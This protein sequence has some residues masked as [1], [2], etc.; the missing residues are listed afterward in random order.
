MNNFRPLFRLAVLSVTAVVAVVSAQTMPPRELTLVIGRGELVQ[1]SN[2]VKTVATSEPKIADVSVVSPR[3]VMIN[4]KGLGKSTVIIWE[5]GGTPSRYNINVQADSME[6]D[7]VKK[8]ITEAMN[9]GT[10]SVTGNLDTVVLSGKAQSVEASKKAEAI[11]STYG[12]KV[13]NLIQVPPPAEL[14]QVMLEVKFAAIDRIALQE[15]GFNFLSRNPTMLGALSTQQFSTPRFS[16]LQFQDQN[17]SNSTLNF[18][19]LLNMFVFRPDLNIGATIRALQSRNLLQMLAEPNLIALEGK[20]ASFLAGGEFPFP[21]LTATST[22]GATAPVVTVQFK[23]FGVQLDFKPEITTDNR[24]HLKLR[25]QVS[26]LDYANAVTLQGY[27]IPAVATRFAETEAI[28]NDGESFAVA[29]LIDNRVI[30][31]MNKIKW[32]G[33]V[34]VVGQ[35]FRSRST[36]KTNEELLVV[37]TPRFVKPLTPDQKPKMPDWVEDFLPPAAEDKEAGTKKKDKVSANTATS[38]KD[39]AK[40]E[41]IGPR[42]YQEPK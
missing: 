20:E 10:V 2:D 5:T 4:A 7:S 11:A 14:R 8:A 41:F 16:Q 9:G 26:S 39:A 21:T 34:P 23:K 32:L 19:D 27:M 42:G 30:Q 17:F 31:S 13:V 15:V 35:L 24:I 1:F 3:E 36:K 38:K 28:L 18:A 22:G 12:K 40:P 37:I 6:F 29:G 33:D 25:P